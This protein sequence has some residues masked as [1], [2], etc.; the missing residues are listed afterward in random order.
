MTGSTSPSPTGAAL[1]GGLGFGSASLAVFAT[2]AFGEG[3]MYQNLGV[4]GAYLVWT[5]LFVGLGGLSL[6]GMVAPALRR[7]FWA[8]FAFGFLAYSA[9][10]ITAYFTLRSAAGEWLGS[11]AGSLLMALV[12]AAAFRKLG[13]LPVFSAIFFVASSAGYFAGS[14]ANDA[15]QGQAGMLLWGA[16]YGLFLGAG[17]GLALARAQRA[18]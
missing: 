14:A 3:W 7:R 13:D 18:G 2:V 12:F 11:L 10:W 16:L 5:L 15:V 4:G 8:A 17:L 1:R 9:G 6:A